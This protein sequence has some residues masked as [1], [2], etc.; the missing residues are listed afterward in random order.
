MDLNK[1][2][3]SDKV[4]AG[5][6]LLLFIA[7][8]LPWFKFDFGPFGGEVT[9]NGWDVGFFWAGIPGLLGLAAAGAVISSKLFDTK[10]PELPIGWGQ[11]FLMAGAIS[12]V[13][14][15]LKLIMGEDVVDRA[16]G[17]FVATIA[18]LG[19]AGGGYLAFQEEKTGGPRTGPAPF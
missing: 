2:T 3:T 18:A 6:G 1:L 15:V 9:A 12:A 13:I 5:S 7:S 4:I 10:L 11:A 17:L 14:V 8:F 19:F 16:Y